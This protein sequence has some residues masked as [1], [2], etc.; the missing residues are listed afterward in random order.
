LSPIS[1]TGSGLLD[2]VDYVVRTSTEGGVPP[3][4]L[5]KTERV[6]ECLGGSVEHDRC[7]HILQD[8]TA[9]PRWS[10]EGKNRGTTAS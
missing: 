3:N 7:W 8:Q 6:A 5:P 2:K 10:F 4:E 9:I 1:I